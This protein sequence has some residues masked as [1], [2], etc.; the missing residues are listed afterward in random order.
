MQAYRQV[1]AQVDDMDLESNQLMALPIDFA[2]AFPNLKKLNIQGNKF[3]NL[4]NDILPMLVSEDIGV[5]YKLHE[6]QINIDSE[7]EVDFLLKKLPA[8]Q[9]L[10]GHNVERVS[11]EGNPN[12]QERSQHT[13]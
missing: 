6:L 11:N 1:L 9:I 12:S 8:L 3:T 10:N 13:D 2:Q 7:N 4:Q 5:N